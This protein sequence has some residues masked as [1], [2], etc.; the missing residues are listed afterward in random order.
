MKRQRL[1]THAL[2]LN[3][4][5]RRATGSQSTADSARRRKRQ[6]RLI[7]ESL[8]NRLLLTASSVSEVPKTV[9][10][11]ERAS[12]DSRPDGTSF[13]QWKGEAVEVVDGEWLAKANTGPV[14][15]QDTFYSASLRLAGIPADRVGPYTSDSIPLQTI[16]SIDDLGA[17]LFK[18]SGGYEP[19]QIQNALA[20]EPSISLVEPNFVYS[21][22][23]V[24]NDLEFD[25]L[26]GLHNTGQT[27]GTEDADID[28]VEAWDVGQGTGESVIGVIDTGIDYTHPELAA[29]IWTNPIECPGGI[30]N[31]IV[32]G[33]DNDGNGFPDDFHGYDFINEDHDPFDDHRHGTHVAGTIGA[34]GDNL[35]GVIGVNPKAQMMA[36]KF[37]SNS[38][39]GSA[40]NALRA[41]RYATMMKRDYGIN[42]VAT[43]NSWGGRS[44]SDFLAEEIA[45]AAEEGVLFVAAAG[46]TNTDNDNESGRPHFPAS[47]PFENIISVAATDHND[48]RSAFSSYGATTVDLGAPGTAI[49][50]TTPNGSYSTFNGTSMAAPHVAGAISLLA[51]IAPHL[52]SLEMREIIFESTD[53][54]PS[55][56]DITATGGRLNL[57]SMLGRLKLYVIHTTPSTN[58][59]VATPPLE[60]TVQFSFPVF[61]SSVNATALNVNEIPANEFEM[62]GDRTV[63][64]RYLTSPVT[65]EGL[66]TIEFEQG[67]I[68]R[69]QHED[70]LEPYS[71]TFRYD[72]L[73]L[74]VEETTP[75]SGQSINIPGG[76]MQIRFNEAFDPSSMAH[77]DFELSHSDVSDFRILSSD[78]IDLGFANVDSEEPIEIA[79]PAGSITDI[80]GNPNARFESEFQLNRADHDISNLFEPIRASCA[81]WVASLSALQNR[82]DR[83][84]R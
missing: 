51:N 47:F 2:F 78:T 71:A 75:P 62:V 23:D 48:E 52:N 44:G 40:F 28:A 7:S 58:E 10:A 70:G 49:L 42:V 54:I 17:V 25:Q 63:L 26:W 50:S 32:D 61:D 16:K 34:V 55:L 69:A 84:R 4:L 80:F 13:I 5:S 33:I 65:S 67:S 35:R 29:N 64:F 36:L 11:F 46:N 56:S 76:R 45:R 41:I 82:G 43:N 22:D 83:H 81:A 59:I 38:G 79:I 12:F 3:P 6:R 18:V 24:P 27:G 30:G 77:S 15:I 53:P 1:S 31:C 39:S 20:L 66:Q 74:A 73:L 9:D 19:T 14:Q 8:E 68:I 60:F 57:R 72:S 37:L 21:I